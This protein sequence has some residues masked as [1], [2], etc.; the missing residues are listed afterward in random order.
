MT[1][2]ESTAQ[3][4]DEAVE[5]AARE[6]ALRRWPSYPSVGFSGAEDR[7]QA[8]M[9][10]ARFALSA[11]TPGA[12][13]YC[14]CHPDRPGMTPDCGI[15]AHR[16]TGVVH[17]RPG[18]DDAR[19]VAAEAEAARWRQEAA[20][21]RTQRDRIQDALRDAEAERDEARVALAALRERIEALHAPAHIYPL[22]DVPG[23]PPDTD[24]DPL[25]TYCQSCTPRDTVSAIEDC[26]W[27]DGM[28]TIGWPCPTL[29][30]LRAALADTAGAPRTDGGCQERSPWGAACTYPAGH[31]GGHRPAPV[32]PDSTDLRERVVMAIA[33]MSP[34]DW[35]L[36]SPVARRYMVEHHGPTSDRVLAVVRP[37]GVNAEHDRHVAAR[38]LREAANDARTNLRTDRLAMRSVPARVAAWLHARADRI[39]R[40]DSPAGG[41]S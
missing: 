35:A 21:V 8:F 27:D 22:L 30:A 1:A 15:R 14:T 18:G 9:A 12:D 16:P 26:C 40:T 24:A 4:P 20:A 23:S 37:D 36:T 13:G 31:E 17:L 38:A 2:D 11:A 19:V 41:A 29:D 5:K 25:T 7:Q 28:D 3:A 39:D 10:G 34:E 6:E 33:N 32:V